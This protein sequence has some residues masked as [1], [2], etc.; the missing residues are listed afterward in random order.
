MRTE[1]IPGNQ[2]TQLKIFP[3]C[4]AAIYLGG[5]KHL[6]HMGLK[7]SNLIPSKKLIRAVGGSNLISQRWLPVQFCVGEMSTKQALYICNNTGKLYFSKATYIDVGILSPHFPTPISL[8]NQREVNWI[9][10][11]LLACQTTCKSTNILLGVRPSHPNK[12]PGHY[13]EQSN[14][15]APVMLELGGMW[16]TPLLLLLPG[17]FWPEVVAPDRVSSMGQIVSSNWLILNRIIS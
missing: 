15:K 16:S 4:G 5:P 10:T 8:T 9:Y 7:G 6:H 2:S 17:P 14:G 3:D 11:S 12:C 1:D 13:I